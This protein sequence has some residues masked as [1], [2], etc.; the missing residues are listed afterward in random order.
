MAITDASITKKETNRLRI[1]IELTP[2]QLTSVESNTSTLSVNPNL[3][4]F[5]KY[6]QTEHFPRYGYQTTTLNWERIF[7]HVL[8][9][10]EEAWRTLA[11]L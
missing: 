9:E 7:D 3:G 11:D 2:E 10:Y 5:R 6:S 4:N 8:E 1:S